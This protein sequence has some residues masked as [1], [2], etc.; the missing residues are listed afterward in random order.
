MSLAFIKERLIVTNTT[1]ISNSI[2]STNLVSAG[3]TKLNMQCIM[4]EKK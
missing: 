2:V 4:D 1:T 3:A